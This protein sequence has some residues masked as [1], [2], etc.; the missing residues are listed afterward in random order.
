MCAQTKTK[1]IFAHSFVRADVSQ[2]APALGKQM[3]D[4]FSAVASSDLDLD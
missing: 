2:H 1:S 4:E 3:L